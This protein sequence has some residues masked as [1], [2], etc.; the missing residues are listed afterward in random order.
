MKYTSLWSTFFLFITES[1]FDCIS[2]GMIHVPV[3]KTLFLDLFGQGKGKKEV[4]ITRKVCFIKL[5]FILL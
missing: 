1:K 5:Y 3:P 4:K 2:W